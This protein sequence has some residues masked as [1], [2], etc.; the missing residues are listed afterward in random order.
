MHTREDFE[1]LLKDS[2]AKLGTHLTVY[3]S[4]EKK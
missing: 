3:G 1:K 2:G 4:V